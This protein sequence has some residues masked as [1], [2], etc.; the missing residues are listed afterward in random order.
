M[1][2][3]YSHLTSTHCSKKISFSSNFN[4]PELTS[5][6]V[7]KK[8]FVKLFL[9]IFFNKNSFSQIVKKKFF[10]KIFIAIFLKNIFFWKKKFSKFFFQ[11]YVFCKKN[12]KNIF[13]KNCFSASFF[14]NFCFANFFR[15]NYFLKKNQRNFSKKISK[16]FIK[17]IFYKKKFRK[18]KYFPKKV[19]PT[20]TNLDSFYQNKSTLTYFNT[21][22]LTSFN[23]NP[24][25]PLTT[26]Y[27]LVKQIKAKSFMIT[28]KEWSSQG[29]MLL[30]L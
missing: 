28:K 18:Q 12:S 16:K 30:D 26:S 27:L 8:N 29:S 19:L 13:F 3:Y 21:F 4:P 2:I 22:H 11:I 15:K 5:T 14:T 20:L 9:Q 10:W 24:F 23:F 6:I 17:K 25:Y 7:G 1:D